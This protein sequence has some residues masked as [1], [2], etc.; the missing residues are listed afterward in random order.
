MDMKSEKQ[1]KTQTKHKLTLYLEK[2]K[3]KDEYI[4]NVMSFLLKV[5][6]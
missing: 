3:Q 5:T 2:K 6:F 1:E 4:K